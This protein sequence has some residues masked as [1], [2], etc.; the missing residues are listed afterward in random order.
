MRAMIGAAGI[1][2]GLFGSVGLMKAENRPDF[3]D[4]SVVA[5][6]KALFLKNRCS[7]CHGARGDGGINLTRRDLSNPDLVFE[8]IAEG[9]EKGGLRMP[10]YRG[11]MSDAETWQV[12]A[13]V[14]S[15]TTKPE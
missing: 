11:V 2:L 14:L 15:L 12:V 4:P 8:A 3:A 9:R 5:S 10:A 1:A 6:G 7:H 13:Y